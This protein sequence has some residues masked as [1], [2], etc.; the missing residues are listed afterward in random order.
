MVQLEVKGMQEILDKIEQL[1]KKAGS[2]QNQALLKAAQPIL[3]DAVQTTQF[4]DR[5]GRLRKGLKISKVKKKGNIRYVLVGIDK[6]DNS[7]IFY[8]KFI[9]FG[10]SKMPARPFLGP[11]YEKNKGKAMDIIREELRKGL[12]LSDK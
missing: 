6:S 8:G 2:I 11:A 5:S 3:G 1:G 10:T 7:E 9:E 4:N 12:G